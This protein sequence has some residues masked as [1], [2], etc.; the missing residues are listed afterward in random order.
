MKPDPTA[1]VTFETLKGQGIP[2]LDAN[3][4]LAKEFLGVLNNKD[5][6]GADR[7]KALLGL[8]GKLTESM[9]EDNSRVWA[10]LNDNWQSAL[11]KEHGQQ[12]LEAKLA[13]VGGLVEAYDKA[14]KAAHPGVNGA[15]PKEFGKSLREAMT[16]TGA[17]N[18]PESVNFLFWLAD[19]LGEGTALGGSPPGGGPKDRAETLFGKG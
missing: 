14:M 2:E 1:E 8:Y 3:N 6:S 17:G 10:E 7:G 18:H 16:L 19:Q 13:K 9:G 11:I 12:N 15:Q 5:L 4:P